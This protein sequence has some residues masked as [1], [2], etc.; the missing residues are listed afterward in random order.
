MAFHNHAQ[1]L[2]QQ[3]DAVA[4]RE[5]AVKG[6]DA[7][8]ESPGGKL[9]FNL[10]AQIEAKRL[11]I[12]TERVWN[13][14]WPRITV[15]YKNMD[16]VHFRAV[17]YR[18]D[19]FIEGKNRNPE[20][21]DREG[22][23]ELVK[24]KPAL[25]WKEAVPNTPAYK[26][27]VAVLKAP[28]SLPPGFYFIIA[29]H[30]PEFRTADNY[31][32]MAPVWVS[33]LA[34]IT[35]TR[36][37]KIEGFV[38]LAGAGEPIAGAVIEPWRMDQQG[39]RIKEPELRT[40]T[41]GFFS[42]KPDWQQRGWLIRAI[43]GEH[44]LTSGQDLWHHGERNDFVGTRTIFFTDRALYRPGQ[45][46]QY[47]GISL[48]LDLGSDK[49]SVSTE[50]ELTVLFLDPNR[51][52]IARQKHRVNAFGSFSGSFTAP[53][54]R[55]MGPMQILTEG[56]DGS[57]SI[58]VE[59]YKRPKFQTTLDRPKQ[60]P[61]LNDRVAMAGHAMGYTGAAVDGAQ[62]K[63]RVVRQVRMP[64]WWGWW[65]GG[66]YT[67][68]DQEI[69]NGTTTTKTDGSFEIAFETKPDPKVLPKHEPTFVFVVN[70]DVTDTAGETR[71]AQQSVRVGYTALEARLAAD[72]WQTADKPV[73]IKVTTQSLD[74]E[75]QVAEG[76][77]KIHALA[78]PDKVHRIPIG[79]NDADLDGWP[80][81]D[82]SSTDKWPLG[83]VVS[84]H[85]FTT[86][87]NGTATVTAQL[88]AGVY[89]AVVETR[90]RFGKAV[91]GLLPIQVVNPGAPRL[92]IKIASLLAA[93][94]WDALPGQ[95][96]IGLWGTG[97]DTGRAFIEIEHRHNLIQRFWTT[98]GHTQQK[99]QVA[100]TEALRGGF[101]VHVTQVRENRSYL[102]SHMVSVP[103]KNKELDLKW[104]HFVSKLTPGQ[105]ETWTATITKPL[106]GPG[107]GATA[108]EAAAAEL[109][110]TLYDESLDAYAP[111]NWPSAFSVFA[112]NYSTLGSHFANSP[113]GFR[114]I[115]TSWGTP[116]KHVQIEFRSFPRELKD[117]FRGYWF[118][119]NY[120]YGGYAGRE[121]FSR[122]ALNMDIAASPPL[123]GALYMSKGVDKPAS[124][125]AE[126]RAGDALLEM[127]PSQTLD[128]FFDG[129][130]KAPNLAEVA[131][132][133]NLNETAFFFPHLMTDSNGVV[134]MTF[135]MPEALTRWKFM[136][137]AHDPAIRNGYLE[138][139]AVTAKDIM[140]QPNPPRFLR[141]GDEIEFTVKVSNMSDATQSGA[142]RLNFAE[143]M[144]AENA[145]KLLGNRKPDQAF[146]LPARESRSFSW[147]IRVPD[148]CGFLTYKAVAATASLSDGEEGAVP[149]LSRRVFVTESLPL[150]IRGPATKKFEFAKLV[151]SGGSKT[152]KHE[153]L[154]VQM[155]SNPAWYAV[156]A[157]PYLMEYPHECSEQVF[158]RLYANALARDIANRNPKIRR[159]F[160]LWKNTPALDSPLEKNQDLKSVMIEETPWL[161]QALAESN[162]RKNVGILFDAN[163]LDSESERVLRKLS[164]MQ[165]GNGQWPWF[166]GGPGDSYITLYI[167]T[168]FGRLRHL[169][170]DINV[171]PALAA[172]ESLDQ[173][174]TAEHKRIME[175][176]EPESYVPSPTVAL[177]LYGR[178]FFLKERPIPAMAQTP[179]EFFLERARQHWLKTGNRQTQAHLALALQRFSGLN[180]SKDETPR[181]IMASMKERSVS[182]EELGMFWRDT[183]Y[184]WSWFHAPIETQALMIEAFDE[185]MQDAK[186]VEDCKVWLLKQK[187]TQDWKTTRAT[188]DAVYALLLRGSDLL[189]SDA[190]VEM[191]LDGID[192]K[193]RH[194][195]PAPS[196]KTS[197]RFSPVVEPGTGF[198]EVRFNRAEISPKLG[199]ITVKKSDK[200]V[201]WGS[202]H[203]QYFEDISK[204]TPHEGT[205]LKLKKA[206]FIKNATPAGLVLD[207]VKGP[208][209]VGDELVVRIELR[210]D[211][212]M[213]YV[214]M[215]DQR[216]SGTEPVNVLS[217][218]KYQDGLGYYE[219]TRDTASHFF[220]S[221]LPKGVYVFEYSTRVQLRGEYQSGLAEI[222][223]MYAPEF[224]SHSESIPVT[225]K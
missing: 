175:R 127:V 217:Q 89:R 35:R 99:I 205:P 33:D 146:E 6:R 63:Y 91:T 44:S 108:S 114:N 163:R 32:A 135:T 182:N 158:N 186:A 78:G 153:N 184:S 119:R 90:D 82:L 64:W 188:A 141:E 187:Q 170:V 203:W 100:I 13:A 98:P 123:A 59:E 58:R 149:V 62:V 94:R 154:A 5:M 37:G 17:A 193:P 165:I 23:Q 128:D 223:C 204:V 3:G 112:Q 168:G 10:I 2:S 105:K 179:V 214:H 139:H 169:G 101:T 195:G 126:S 54:D 7:F 1:V 137:V 39:R 177:Y 131:A 97:Y 212:D 69:A 220:I 202:M 171:A 210:T 52:E 12:V 130:G 208:V 191:K 84:E 60:A 198:Y 29:S 48:N 103:W 206:L 72:N 111:H 144:T 38:L 167:T 213:E 140:V 183:E 14:P 209:K 190:L 109:V 180:N 178:S 88:G 30:D 164:E 27:R 96:F 26:E 162:A 147:R 156:L 19:H 122:G 9:C 116:N 118:G 49:Y 201:A 157:L 174:I 4:A 166:P 138:G 207:P 22:Q 50:R 211:R 77:I 95:D 110:A 24:T 121:R 196:G 225:A 124:I 136:G 92:D 192:I 68:Q 83:K 106:D 81:D 125:A 143:A 102:Q 28:A 57:T 86:G 107:T 41:N 65:R 189:A 161:Q 104:E 11:R 87:T 85:G 15:N 8:P 120:G 150:P 145:D 80:D 115:L 159:I 113:N 199:Q 47:K 160:D 215:K 76:S 53:R 222:Q 172:L 152:L 176:P 173:W 56:N 36:S 200:G 142:V 61:R 218:Y 40:D 18:W 185:I 67:G 70:A 75:P 55:L 16:V 197:E 134:R 71:S 181:G 45:T 155:V 42:F 73:E 66:G 151:S 43:H 216:G 21:L 148:G 20:N 117:R 132:R 79:G 25:E 51:K 194:A 221:Y 219:S 31:L 46:V 74:G 224:N 93:P 129:G 34:L 133:K